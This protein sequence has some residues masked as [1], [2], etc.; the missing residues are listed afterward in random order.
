MERISKNRNQ[1][2]LGPNFNQRWISQGHRYLRMRDFDE[3]NR[4]GGLYPTSYCGP[5]EIM[6]ALNEDGK[7][8][9]PEQI[10][11][12][13]G[14]WKDQKKNQRVGDPTPNNPPPH[15]GFLYDCTIAANPR[16]A[17]IF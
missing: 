9:K 7:S 13:T 2:F 16:T 11:M 10:L 1:F 12:T 4:L 6:M 5:R 14:S 17:F 15:R 8:L 3:K